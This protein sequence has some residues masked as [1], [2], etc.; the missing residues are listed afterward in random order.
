M[1]FSSLA[2][3]RQPA[4]LPGVIGRILVW[5]PAWTAEGE[6]LERHPLPDAGDSASVEKPRRK[7]RSWADLMRHVFELDALK[8]PA[9]GGRMRVLAVI[10]DPDSIRAILDCLGLAS[11]P[12]PRPSPT[13]SDLFWTHARGSAPA[14]PAGV[15]AAH[16]GDLPLHLE[17]LALAGPDTPAKLTDQAL[18]GT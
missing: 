18:S 6:G 4:E 5:E 12:P 1:A 17:R 8:C 9:C 7:N 3:V 15:C 10:Q 13:H 2:L 16:A 11:R 14:V